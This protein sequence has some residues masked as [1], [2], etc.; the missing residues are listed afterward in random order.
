MSEH[1]DGGIYCWK[2]TPAVHQPEL[3]LYFNMIEF[4]FY[5]LLGTIAT[6]AAT[7]L[8]VDSEIF[9]YFRSAVLPKSVESGPDLIYKIRLFIF[10]LINCGY[11]TSVWVSA[12]V[13][14][15]TLELYDIDHFNIIHPL[16]RWLGITLALHRLSNWL[17]VLYEYLR[18]GRVLT[19]D[20]TYRRDS[21]SINSDMM[22]IG[23]QDE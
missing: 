17:H 3:S 9:Q 2:R 15:F 19:H 13:S 18:K 22:E 21:S 1:D 23:E 4:A 12:A 16:I 8:V 7:E 6:E 10:K 14:Y 5:L 20:V 11:C